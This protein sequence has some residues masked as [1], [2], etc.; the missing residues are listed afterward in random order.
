MLLSKPLKSKQQPE[1]SGRRCSLTVIVAN[2][3][4]VCFLPELKVE[5]P[6][7]ELYSTIL[8]LL[9]DQKY[10]LKWACDGENFEIKLT[11]HGSLLNAKTL[12]VSF[13]CLEPCK[14]EKLS[15]H[16]KRIKKIKSTVLKG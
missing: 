16:Q 7:N 15:R 6:H 3:L 10:D 11:L 5:G 1:E 13:C 4:L 2:I 9:S 14:A 12:S 8:V